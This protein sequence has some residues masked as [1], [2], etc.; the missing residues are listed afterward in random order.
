M[1]L[2]DYT[3]LAG[4][5]QRVLGEK[6][7]L[8]DQILNVPGFSMACRIDEHYF[9]ALEPLLLKNLGTWS[10]VLPSRVLKALIKT[11]NILTCPPDREHMVAL[12]TTWEGLGRFVRIKACFVQ[13]EFFDRALKVFGGRAKPLPLSSLQVHSDDRAGVE[14]FFKGKTPPASWLYTD[15]PG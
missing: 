2:T 6:Y 13:G 3:E 4:D 8:D 7:R 5:L 11:G 10:A 9:L 1:T 15:R 14:E 12:R